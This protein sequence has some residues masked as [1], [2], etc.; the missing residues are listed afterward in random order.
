MVVMIITI[1]K[2][3]ILNENCDA[4]LCPANSSGFMGGGV[5]AVIKQV[6]GQEIEDEAISEAPINVG[7]AVATCAGVLRCKH[8]IHAPTMEMPGERS[9][10]TKVKHALEAALELAEELNLHVLAIP[11]MGT[12]IGGLDKEESAKAMIQVLKEHRAEALE[13]VVLVDVD[14]D[15]VKAWEKYR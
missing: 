1:H 5:A 4:I 3:S 7:K 12:G 15:M 10:E 14:E 2:A 13:E 6:G 8:I 11:G 9:D